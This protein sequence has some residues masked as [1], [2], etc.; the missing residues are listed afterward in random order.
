MENRFDEKAAE[1]KT[2]AANGKAPK[3]GWQSLIAQIREHGATQN[4]TAPK[5]SV[6]S[7]FQGRG[8]IDHAVGQLVVAGAGEGGGATT[9]LPHRPAPW[10][11]GPGLQR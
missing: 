11:G 8:F 4:I 7:P 5:R 9:P 10:R 6:K 1:I 2:A 3:Q